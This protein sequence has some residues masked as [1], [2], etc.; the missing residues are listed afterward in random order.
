MKES[1][2]R[3]LS[4]DDWTA[5]ALKVLGEGGLAAVAIE[6]IAARLGATKGSGYW[7]FRGRPDLV[8]ATLERWEAV[9]TDAIIEQAERGADP[10]ERLRELFRV[11][12]GRPGPYTVELALLAS[13][14]DPLVAP[15]V[16]RVTRRRIDYLRSLFAE[17][18]LDPVQAQRR[19]LLAY[20]TYLGHAQLTRTDPAAVPT[21]G[22]ERHEYLDSLLVTLIAGR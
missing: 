10:D 12:L 7:H 2:N 6:P 4:R 19:A 22:R 16:Q 13:A 14:D 18:G 17:L 3:R 20:T 15:T 21:D 11:V 1:V 9:H 8:A 5:E